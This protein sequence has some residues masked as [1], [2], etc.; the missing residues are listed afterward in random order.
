MRT[1]KVDISI[2]LN[3]DDLKLIK[4]VLR[5]SE[6]NNISGY[7]TYIFN[8]LLND[9]IINPVTSDEAKALLGKRKV[10]PIFTEKLV[11]QHLEIDQDVL[12]I[13]FMNTLQDDLGANSYWDVTSIFAYA[14]CQVLTNPAGSFTFG[15]SQ[16]DK[17][18]IENVIDKTKLAKVN[19]M[20]K[21]GEPDDSAE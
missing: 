8:N 16:Y 19:A 13:Y 7:F 9:K 1:V 12:S 2:Y 17:S 14:L 18:L 15:F 3:T 10:Q 6:F 11:T 5:T 20:V 21:E 4:K